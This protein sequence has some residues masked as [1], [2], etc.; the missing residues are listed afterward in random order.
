MKKF[1]Y[2]GK[3]ASGVTT[4]VID[5]A[6]AQSAST[7]LRAK[8]ITPISIEAVNIEIKKSAPVDGLSSFLLR[9]SQKELIMF[10]RQMYTLTHS[11][12]PISQALYGLAANQH[13]SLLKRAILAIHADIESGY[14]L[15]NALSNQPRIFN[16]L[17]VSLIE[18]G[19]NTGQLDTAFEQAAFYLE[20][21][22]ETRQQ[23]KAATRYPTIVLATLAIA[24]VIINVFIVPQ[25]S[26]IFENFDA[27]LPLP[28]II[29][30]S[31]SNFFI[32]YWYLIVAGVILSFLMLNQYLKTE[33]GLRNWDHIK[34]K[35]PIIGPIFFHATLGR[36]TRSLSIMLKAG[37][38]ILRCLSLIQGSIGNAYI[39]QKMT[40][41]IDDT[42]SGK[43]LAVATRNSGLFTP[44]VCQMFQVGEAS[45]R[46]DSLMNDVATFYEREVDYELKRF[47]SAIEPILIIF[48][49][50]IVLILALGVFLPLWDMSSHIMSR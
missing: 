35:I 3:N 40:G 37:L 28:T 6:N 19:E 24:L 41:I 10:T 7:Q 26:K 8:G 12:V 16:P 39:A 29:I 31:F 32:H 38:P 5:A 43:P 45:G 27:E 17:Y 22:H 13:N 21:E 30:V 34:L 20:R 33:S 50:G 23:I 49:A 4:G 9:V 1:S 46:M 36:F 47:G 15:H 42:R 48:M 44:L 11:G 2:K 25:F 14:S 18:V